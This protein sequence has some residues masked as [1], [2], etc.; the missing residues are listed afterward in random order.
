MPQLIR[1]I[2]RSSPLA[3]WQTNYIK[4]LLNKLYSHLKIEII[5]IT[6]TGDSILDRSLDKIGGKGLF[7]KEL[8]VAL[9]NGSADLAVHSAKDL[10]AVLP[11]EFM[12]SGFLVR[13]DARDVFVAKLYSSLD[14]LPNGAVIGTSSSRRAM[15]LHRYYPHCQIKL[16]RGNIHTRLKKLNDGEYDGI[17]LAAAG[18]NRL[19]LSQLIKQYLNKAQFI[20]SIGQGA[21]A[22]ELLKNNTELYNLVDILKDADTDIAIKTE[23]EVGRILQAGCSVPIA[24]HAWFEH[25]LL[26]LKSCIYDKDQGISCEFYGS[27]VREEYLNLATNCANELLAQGANIILE[28]YKG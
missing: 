19:G 9:L 13:E 17:V 2:S 25:G 15:L 18:L 28:K 3:L 8:E 12:L 24:A 1:I 16:L 21:L 7:T 10:P 6:T 11:T 14:D 20:P 23:R 5:G 22:I 27:S 26:H 4:D